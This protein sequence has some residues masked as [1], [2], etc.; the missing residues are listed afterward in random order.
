MRSLSSSEIRETFLRYFTEKGHT[1]VPGNSLIPENDTTLLF[2]NAGMVQFKKVFLGIE[3]LPYTRATTI[4]K[5]LRVSG[6][7]NDIDEVGS[8]PSHN[9]FYEMLGNFSFGD[10]FKR[11]AIILAWELLTQ[12]FQLPIERLW[13]SVYTDDNEAARLWEEA[14][15]PPERILRF[16]DKENF[17]SMG[18]TGPCGPSSEI[19]YYLGD[20]IAAQRPEGVNSED[21]DYLEFWNLVFMQYNRDTK[22]TLTRLPHPSIDTGMGFERITTILQ[23]VK[24]TYETDLFVPIIHRIMTLLGKDHKHYQE[25]AI[26]YHIIADHSRSLALM[27]TDGVYPG[28]GSREYVLRR[29]LRRAAYQGQ[30]LGLTRPCLAEGVGAVS[31]IMSEPYPE[32]QAKRNEIKEIVTTEEERFSH[33]LSTGLRHLE[34]V[35]HHSNEKILSGR[36]A[37]T[38]YDTYGFPLDLTEKIV[39]ERG[40]RIDGKGFTKAMQEQQTRSRQGSVFKS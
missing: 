40:L 21:H 34:K 13:F 19:H 10:Y 11:E 30:T 23:G 15:A 38:L 2:T 6:K 25:N 31:T 1:I 33:T 22:G 27:M 29:L 3:Q 35:L 26:A 20:N 8:S 12:V 7:H 16:G 37:F 14:G 4:Q 5:V 18:D 28:N 24:S 39:A 9:T 32:L 17:W 36:E